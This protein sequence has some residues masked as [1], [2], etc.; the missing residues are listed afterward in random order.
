MLR[1]VSRALAARARADILGV[2]GRADLERAVAD[3]GLDLW[4][5]QELSGRI[6]GLY[7]D[8]V[9]AVRRGLWPPQ[10]RVVVAHELGHALLGHE[11]VGHDAAFYLR[12]PGGARPSASTEAAAQ[13]FAWTLLVGRPA[14]DHA[15]LDAQLH[16]GSRA[17]LPLDFLFTALSIL[18]YRTPAVRGSPL[19]DLA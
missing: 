12:Q 15:G 4:Y 10:Q 3:A 14:R 18:T 1:A 8:G 11:T 19:L 16:T 13:V 7:C 5:D 2:A 9:I 6:Q 17:G